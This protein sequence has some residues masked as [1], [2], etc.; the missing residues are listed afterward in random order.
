MT[1]IP[2]ITTKKQLVLFPLFFL[3]Y[4]P[5]PFSLIH[6]TLKAEWNYLRW[7]F[8]GTICYKKISLANWTLAA[9]E[10]W[11]SM[12]WCHF[13]WDSRRHLRHILSQSLI[14]IA[15]NGD[16]FLVFSRIEQSTQ[17]EIRLWF[18]FYIKIRLLNITSHKLAA[19]ETSMYTKAISTSR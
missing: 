2:T 5:F 17:Q 16:I 1:T 8:Q 11:R 12:S 15:N 18:D 14:S 10:A 3:D 7:V 13:Y 4:S 6:I 9:Y 19:R